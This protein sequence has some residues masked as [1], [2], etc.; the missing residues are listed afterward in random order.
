MAHVFLGLEMQQISSLW[1]SSSTP[2]VSRLQML[3]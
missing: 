2:K 1:S 3:Q